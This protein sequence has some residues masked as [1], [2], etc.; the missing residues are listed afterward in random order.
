MQCPKITNQRI[1]SHMI[2]W[3]GEI[4]TPWIPLLCMGVVVMTTVEQAQ[5][6]TP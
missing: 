2:L 5:L 6:T 1:W 3:G 4:R